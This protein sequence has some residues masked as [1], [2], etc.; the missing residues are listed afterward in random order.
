M[1]SILNE[2]I[3]SQFFPQIHH[4]TTKAHI[5]W[6]D[7][8][9]SLSI[10]SASL[11]IQDNFKNYHDCKTILPQKN[12]LHL[13]II[14]EDSPFPK[15]IMKLPWIRATWFNRDIMTHLSHGNEKLVKPYYL[16]NLRPMRICDPI[17]KDPRMMH[18]Q[19]ISI[20]NP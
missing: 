18:G 8:R 12:M 7:G 16:Q 15:H 4:G 14:M 3:S 1:Y 10:T 6:V 13:W 11:K 2:W 9:P 5:I 20:P 17:G 19:T